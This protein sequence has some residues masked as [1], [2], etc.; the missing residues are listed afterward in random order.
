[1]TK[2]I[3]NKGRRIIYLTSA[4]EDKLEVRGSIHKGH[5]SKC[6]ENIHITPKGLDVKEVPLHGRTELWHQ[7]SVRFLK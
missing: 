5:A 3:R 1:M 7:K 4:V 2:T 6:L